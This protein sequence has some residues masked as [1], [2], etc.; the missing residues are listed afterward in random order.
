MNDSNSTND[1]LSNSSD[2]SECHTYTSQSRNSEKHKKHCYTSRSSKSD[3]CDSSRYRKSDS[4]D[5]CELK[6]A[7]TPIGIWNLQYNSASAL[8][9]TGT[10]QWVSQLVLNGDKTLNLFSA[11]DLICSPY[12][13]I[14]TPGA[15]VWDIVNDKKYKVHVTHIGYRPSDGCTEVFY[16]TELT[17]KLNNKGTRLRFCGCSQSYHVTDL[18]MCSPTSEDPLY[19]D[20]C[21]TKVMEPK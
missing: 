6:C 15:G 5:D 12:P 17:F 4:C 8:T 20:G 3:S 16:K 9:T 19:F 7:A 14:L 18:T 10:L 1:H 13:Y 11:P 2:S 21:G